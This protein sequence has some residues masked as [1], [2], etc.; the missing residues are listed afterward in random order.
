MSTIPPDREQTGASAPAAASSRLLLTL[1]VVLG[2]LVVGLGAILAIVLSSRKP[3]AGLQERLPGMDRLTPAGAAAPEASAF[4]RAKVAT[5]DGTP[6]NLPGAWP[7]FRGPDGDGIAKN[8]GPIA[9][10]WKDGVPRVLWSA[11][12]G[13]GYAGA[14]IRNGRVYLL[15]YDQTNSADALR[16]L[17]LAD[18][19]EIWRFSYPVK[20][21][22]NHGMSRTVPTVT[23]KYAVS[24][25]PKC[26]LTCVDAEKG[27]FVWGVDLAQQFNS[28]VPQWYAGQ[29][30]LVEGDRVIV[31]LGG[32]ALM[33]AFD[34]ATG[35]ELWRTPNAHDWKMTHASIATMEVGGRRMYVYCGS[36]GVAGVDAADGKLLWETDAW[37][38]SIAT[39][40]TPV[41]VGG[42]KLFFSG[43]YNAGA[44]ML[45][46]EEQGGTFTTKPLFRLKATEFGATQ[47]TPALFNGHLFGIRPDGQLTCLDLDGKIRWTSGGATKFGL[48]PFLIANDVVFAMNDEGQLTLAEASTEKFTK[49]AQARVLQ[50]HDSWAP[51]SI[52]GSRLLARDLTRMVC[53]D[54]SGEAK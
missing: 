14:S 4:T 31:G 50:G 49:L 39:V 47:Q 51:L 23:E 16:C 22:R 29:C 41:P 9:R 21:K 53:L 38:I 52:A 30:P 15:D 10:E 54:V 42:G 24:M 26:H 36:G 17:S 8:V 12:L 44:L 32:D 37:V 18:G 33:A 13:E 2:L 20:T 43:G 5:G 35:K 1:V 25:G 40:P 7:K 45:Q 48:G 6:A 34:L 3:V 19:K 11:D 28:E 46:V 27:T